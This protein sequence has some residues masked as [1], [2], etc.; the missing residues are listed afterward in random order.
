MPPPMHPDLLELL[1]EQLEHL[2]AH[3]IK[4]ELG[5]YKCHLCARFAFVESAL[6]EAWK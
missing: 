5:R 3:A 2:Y 6:W 1:W 4:C